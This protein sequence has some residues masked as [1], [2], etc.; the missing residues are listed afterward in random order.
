MIYIIF[1]QFLFIKNALLSMNKNKYNFIEV[2]VG[3]N[4]TNCYNVYQLIKINY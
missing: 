2:C 1:N 3:L 4:D